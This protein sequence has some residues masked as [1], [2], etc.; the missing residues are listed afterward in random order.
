MTDSNKLLNYMT[1][2]DGLRIMFVGDLHLDGAIHGRHKNYAD[3]CLECLSQILK[4]VMQNHINM[5]IF[6]GDISDGSLI[7]DSALQ[8]KYL[9]MFAILNVFTDYHVYSLAGNHDM[10][11][12]VNLY[13][14]LKTTT[15]IKTVD[16]MKS[17]YVKDE[18][19][20]DGGEGY[21]SYLKIG[22][23]RI[24]LMNYA[25]NYLFLHTESK[26]S[27]SN[28]NDSVVD[29]LVSHADW[30]IPNVTPFMPN[31]DDTVLLSEATNLE[32][33]DFIINGHIHHPVFELEVDLLNQ[34]AVYIN[35]G[36][37][38]TPTFDPD[39][40]DH[41]YFPVIS[42]TK[43]VE[44]GAEVCS[45]AVSENKIEIDALSRFVELADKLQK[46]EELEQDESEDTADS[47]ASVLSAIKSI[48]SQGADMI[49][50][51]AETLTDNDEVRKIFLTTFEDVTKT[52]QAS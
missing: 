46:C 30:Y 3:V 15:L 25:D 50:S 34:K 41:V 27:E 52:H 26:V 32:G 13:Y 9:E 17:G 31:S 6:S 51:L 14:L 45:L 44:N 1:T 8:Q 18:F 20:V 42:L 22:D 28:P 11:S 4:S 38:T 43:T 16:T 33:V 36:C 23:L 24:H 40:W 10:H 48:V 19:F 12:G 37:Y 39:M 5:I 29:L 7:R 21:C 47:I 2:P 35:A 49:H